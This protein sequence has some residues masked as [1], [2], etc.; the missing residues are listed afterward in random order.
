MCE[1]Q[2][3]NETALKCSTQCLEDKINVQVFKEKAQEET[4]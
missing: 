4:G 1:V 2:D 3:S